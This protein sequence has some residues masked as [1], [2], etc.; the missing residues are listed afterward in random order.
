M[1]CSFLF[2][3]SCLRAELGE[4]PRV[5]VAAQM[6]SDIVYKYKDSLLAGLIVAGWDPV[7][8]GQVYAIPLG[9]TLVRQEWT[10]GGSG[11]TFIYGFCDENYKQGMKSNECVKFVR[12]AVGHAVFRDGSSGGV[13]RTAVITESGVDRQIFNLDTKAE[14]MQ[15]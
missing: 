11:S 8:G 4:M 5:R 15:E 12:K 9:G 10:I 13:C 1:I 6:I 14:F 3:L 7:E 2:K